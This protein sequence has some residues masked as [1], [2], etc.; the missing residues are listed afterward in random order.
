MNEVGASIS[1]ASASNP[2]GMFLQ[3]KMQQMDLIGCAGCLSKTHVFDGLYSMCRR[4]C[5]GCGLSLKENGHVAI[6]CDKGPRD[7]S[8][9][10]KLSREADEQG[11]HDQT[12]A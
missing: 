9:A 8:E 7:K 4:Y 3:M 5:P 2:S 1:S 12:Q 10:I 6:D 11:N